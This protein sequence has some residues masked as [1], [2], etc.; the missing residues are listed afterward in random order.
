M[1]KFLW[2]GGGSESSGNNRIG[3]RL[4]VVAMLLAGSLLSACG[5][6]GGESGDVVILRR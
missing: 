4:P 6:S 5:G 1:T 2:I 3:L